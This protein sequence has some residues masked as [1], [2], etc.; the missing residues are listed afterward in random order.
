MIRFFSLFFIAA[1]AIMCQTNGKKESTAA[2]AKS[3][4]DPASIRYNTYCVSCHGANA[5][6]FIGRE[7]KRGNSRAD[8]IN[9][10]KTGNAE[11]GMPAFSALFKPKEIEE[12]AD[13]ILAKIEEGKSKPK[14]ANKNGIFAHAS[15]T[16]K[17]DTFAT[18]LSNPWG[19]A[20][21]PNGDMLVTDRNG[22]FYRIG[23]DRKRTEIA[24]APT[25]L[26]KGQGGLLDVVLHP[27]FEQNQFVYLSYSKFKEEDGAKLATTAIYRAKLKGNELVEGQ[28]IFV[29][30]PYQKTQHHYGCRIVFDTEGYMFFAVGDR[31]QHKDFLPQRLDNDMGKIHR[32][33]DDG[34]V[35][36]DNPF[37]GS[38]TTRH[39]IWSYGHRNPQGLVIHPTTGI[40]WED[41]H[42]PKG[43]DELNIIRKAKNYGWPVISYGINYDGS[44]LT[45][46]KQKEGMEQPEIYWLPSIGPCGL[47]FNTSDRYPAWNGDLLTGSMSFKYLQRCKMEN[48]RVV[49]QEKLLE[50]VGRVR[51]ISVGKDNY[52]YVAVENP[53]LIFRLLP[54]Q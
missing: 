14:N 34:R 30:M 53:G 18:G 52:I 13:F 6:G 47:A 36:N 40:I 16:V 32:L 51:A 48:N 21:L 45:P 42:G 15:M 20:F 28:D 31:G 24:G 23:T 8:I 4:T 2:V 19:M 44:I 27:K 35:P 39:S 41:E 38:D 10:I 50:D 11:G 33:H 5:E 49:K 17:L 43:G 7:W 1:L 25:V 9:S 54:V 29:A 37:V 12:L 22:K 46:Y 26:A 3:A